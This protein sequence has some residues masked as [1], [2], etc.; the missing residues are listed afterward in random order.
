M[1]RAGGCAAL[2]LALSQWEIRAASTM[3]RA[4]RENPEPVHRH[5][6]ASTA[7]E[8][9]GEQLAPENRKCHQDHGEAEEK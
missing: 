9:S 7:G 6:Q 2:S 5:R 4:F 3:R 1:R 8:R